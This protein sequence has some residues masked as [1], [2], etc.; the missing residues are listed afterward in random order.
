MCEY[1]PLNILIKM[2]KKH[3]P[4]IKKECNI[5]KCIFVLKLFS[6]NSKNPYTRMLSINEKTEN[7][8]CKIDFLYIKACKY[9][10]FRLI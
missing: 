9:Y 4:Y 6:R 3:M 5:S 8:P 10:L 1:F 7:M 2:L